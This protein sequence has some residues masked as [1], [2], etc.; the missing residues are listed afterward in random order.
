ME[1]VPTID[2]TNVAEAAPT[3]ETKTIEEIGSQTEVNT[4]KKKTSNVIIIVI[5]LI[6]AACIY[7]MD[8]ITSFFN[9]TI[10]PMIK[11]ED[12]NFFPFD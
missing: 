10:L 1:G 12:Y 8:N 3:Q 6:I 2:N 9:T 7:F 5:L 11:N 4:Q